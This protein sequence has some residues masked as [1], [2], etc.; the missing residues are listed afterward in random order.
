MG[1]EFDNEPDH[2]GKLRREKLEEAAAAI[3]NSRTLVEDL[4][5]ETLDRLQHA[6]EKARQAKGRRGTS[7]HGL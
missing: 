5:A 1:F 3:I 4:P 2:G 7:G 6:V